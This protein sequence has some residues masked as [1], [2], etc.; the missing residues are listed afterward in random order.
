MRD[1]PGLP[2]EMLGA[3]AKLV[4][5]GR[6]QP[7]VV[8]GWA[9]PGRFPLR[10][11]Q[12]GLFEVAQ[13][14][15]NHA[16]ITLSAPEAELGESA[17]DLITVGAPLL[18]NEQ[19]ERFGVATETRCIAIEGLAGSTGGQWRRHL[20]P[21]YTY[22]TPPGASSGWSGAGSTSVAVVS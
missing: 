14:T 21:F 19:N 11:N 17:T 15:V 12:P 9:S 16:R 18:E 22:A 1:P 2:F 13:E 6:G 10:I 8:A 20:A 5:P 3:A 4:L 7:I